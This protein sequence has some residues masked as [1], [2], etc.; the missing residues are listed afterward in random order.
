MHARCWVS[1]PLGDV[2]NGVAQAASLFLSGT[3][4]QPVLL[5]A[6]RL[7]YT[8]PESVSRI[9]RGTGSWQSAGNLFAMVENL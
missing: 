2:I 4:W 7:K 3:G 8:R 9:E 5:L 6:L 1:R